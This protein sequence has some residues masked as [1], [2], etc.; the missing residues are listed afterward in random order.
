M[1]H[2]LLSSHGSPDRSRAARTAAH[3]QARRRA[4]HG[5]LSRRRR[6]AITA[7]SSAGDDDCRSPNARS[8]AAVPSMTGAP[9]EGADS[10]SGQWHDVEGGSDTKWSTTIGRTPAGHLRAGPGPRGHPWPTIRDSWSAPARFA[11][12][13]LPSRLGSRPF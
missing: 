5:A 9:A 12:R 6:L 7:P 4:G 11:A 13:R 1:Y 8:P 3:V 2:A 10:A